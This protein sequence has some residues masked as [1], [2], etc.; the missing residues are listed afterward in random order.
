M[1][2]GGSLYYQC[3]SCIP[4]VYK[5]HYIFIIVLIKNIVSQIADKCN[6]NIHISRLFNI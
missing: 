5:N 4:P 3:F 1:N 6:I 2:A